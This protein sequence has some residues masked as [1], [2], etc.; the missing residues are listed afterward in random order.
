MNDVEQRS[1]RLKILNTDE[2]AQELAGGDSYIRTKNGEVKGL[3]VTTDKNPDAPEIIVV[4]TGKRIVANAH[5][6]LK[7]KQYVPVYIKQDVNQWKYLGDYKAH[8]YHQDQETIEKH[9]RHRSAEDVN[10]ILFLS[11]LDDIDVSVKGRSVPDPQTKQKIEKAAIDAVTSFYKKQG[12]TVTDR[13]ND[14]VGYDLF[15]Q[16]EKTILKIEVK[17]T[18]STE[19]RFFISRNEKGKSADPLW[20]LAVVTETLTNPKLEVFDTASML[21]R[22]CFDALCW[23]CTIPPSL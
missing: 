23:E 8:S 21:N 11:A 4:G 5:L 18:A 3:A 20:R 16:K 22:F 7:S 12:F 17:G 6:F 14:N 10:G 13:Q 2:L 1:I 15:I 19:Q 9:R